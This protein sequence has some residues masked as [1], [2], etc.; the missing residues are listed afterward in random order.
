MEIYEEWL[1]K[2]KEDLS[3]AELALEFDA[4]V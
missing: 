1:F 4:S 2:A 3:L